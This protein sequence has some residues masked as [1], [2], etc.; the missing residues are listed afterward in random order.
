MSRISV[1]R[2]DFEPGLPQL[3]GYPEPEE[4]EKRLRDRIEFEKLRKQENSDL[5]ELKEALRWLEEHWEQA[6]PEDVDPAWLVEAAAKAEQKEREATARFRPVIAVLKEAAKPPSGIFE[7]DVHQLLR[8]GIGVLEGWLIFYQRF[9]T[10]LAKHAGGRR[11]LAGVLRARPVEGQIDYSQLSQE[12]IA[13][14]PKIRAAL[15]K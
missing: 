8:D 15:A 1:L 2:R 6:A 7:A 14:Y 3:L 13:R 11:K 12:H 9:R 5:A 10:V 4:L